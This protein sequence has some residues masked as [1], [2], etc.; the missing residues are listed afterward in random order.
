M[1]LSNHHL[2]FFVREDIIPIFSIFLHRSIY[3]TGF[4]VIIE[5]LSILLLSLNQCD[6]NYGQMGNAGGSQSLLMAGHLIFQLS[7]WAMISEVSEVSPSVA[8]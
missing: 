3:A 5:L 7:W 8:F 1:F 6:D 4:I 2:G